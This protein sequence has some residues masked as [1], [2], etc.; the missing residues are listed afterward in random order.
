MGEERR[1]WELLLAAVIVFAVNLTIMMC[2]ALSPKLNV[3]MYGEV[4]ESVA[5][6]KPSP[7]LQD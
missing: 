2:V 4:V 6:D 3:D 1:Q 5:V 7:F